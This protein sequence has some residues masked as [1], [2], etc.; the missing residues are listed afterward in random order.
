MDKKN[1]EFT[2]AATNEG[3][4]LNE[5][6]IVELSDLHLAIIGGGIGDTIL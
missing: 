3:N 1:F 4:A 2:G 5:P 6:M